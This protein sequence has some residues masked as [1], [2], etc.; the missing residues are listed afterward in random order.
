MPADAQRPSEA[1][2][3]PRPTDTALVVEPAVVGGRPRSKVPGAIAAAGLSLFVVLAVWKPW[4][5]PTDGPRSSAPAPSGDLAA[6]SVEPG[7]TGHVLPVDISTFP[8]HALLLAATTSQPAWGVRAVVLRTGGPIFT[9][10]ANVVERWVMLPADVGDG[11]PAPPA[12]AIAQPDDDVAAIGITSPND[13]LPLDIRVWSLPSTG[14]P[15]RVSPFAIAGPEAG[16]WLW[17]ADRAQATDHGTW[18]AGAYEIEVLVGPRI[19]RVPVTIPSASPTASRVQTPLSQPPFASVL[20]TFAPGLFALADGGAQPL[21]DSSSP[22]VDEREAWLGP[23]AGLPPVAV[24][25]GGA[26][27]GFGRLFAAGDEPLRVDLAQ[28]APRSLPIETDINIVAVEPG[29]RQAIVAFPAAGGFLPDGL[30]HMT[31]RWN[32]AGVNH[33]AE[34]AIEV[35]PQVPAT[36]PNAPLDAMTRWFG[37][38]DRRDVAAREPLIFVGDPAALDACGARTVITASDRLFGVV[39]PPRVA[40]VGVRLR[41]IGGT[42]DIPIRFAPEAVPRLTVVALPEAGLPVGAYDLVVSRTSDVGEQ[43]TTQRICMGST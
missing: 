34:S 6:G 24:V 10:Q 32:S 42:A 9:R 23:A 19:V 15:L 17:L 13:A 28:L 43:R 41:Q 5:G 18:P 14:P 33:S 11:S 35:Q 26:V 21:G 38:L 29:H 7:P 36:L 1:P 39:V 8:S 3:V 20:E 16:S 31:V 25:T 12:I 40:V 4:Q 27:T 2:S 30:Y 22:P 37:L